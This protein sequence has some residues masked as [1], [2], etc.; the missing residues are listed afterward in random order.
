VGRLRRCL[1]PAAASS[2]QARCRPQQSPGPAPRQQP[3]RHAQQRGAQH[4]Q[5][6][7]T[8]WTLSVHALNNCLMRCASYH[9]AGTPEAAS[10][11]CVHRCSSKC[12]VNAQL[13]P[14]RAVLPKP[15]TSFDLFMIH[16]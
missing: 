7:A 11:P 12:I 6:A 5:A 2:L 4:L 3:L 16:K 13:N 1:P 8:A 15:H 14:C 9:A 10:T